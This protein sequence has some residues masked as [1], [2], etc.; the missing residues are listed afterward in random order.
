MNKSRLTPNVTG[1]LTVKAADVAKL[2]RIAHSLRQEIGDP[3]LPGCARA[4]YA[5]VI[6]AVDV[7]IMNAGSAEE[8]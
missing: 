5:D 4:N 6:K 1:P 7:L 3:R 2:A 8:E